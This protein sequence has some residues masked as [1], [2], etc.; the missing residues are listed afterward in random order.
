M[1]VLVPYA[2]DDRV[3]HILGST[4]VRVEAEPVAPGVVELIG[5]A[6]LFPLVPYDQVT[7]D[8]TG[9]VTGIHRLAP[10]WVF[11][12]FC[13]TPALLGAPSMDD[14]SRHDIAVEALDD[15]QWAAAKLGADQVVLELTRRAPVYRGG[16]FGVIVAT[17]SRVWFDAWRKDHPH[18]AFVQLV[19]APTT[20]TTFETMQ[21]TLYDDR[22]II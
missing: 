15:D 8:D 18:V 13:R 12:V 5:Y 11:D 10:M 4:G 3:A 19:R 6:G 16:N 9:K 20:T 17:E 22:E 2:P 1:K 7:V 21:H 14:P